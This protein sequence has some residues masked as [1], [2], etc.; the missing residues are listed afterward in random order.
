[1][2]VF[3]IVASIFSRSVALL[4]DVA[5][6][7][8]DFLSALLTLFAERLAHRPSTKLMSYGFSRGT[9]V[10]AFVNG[11]S[12]ILLSVIILGQSVVRL[13]YPEPVKPVWM[14]VAALIAFLVD[15]VIVWMLVHGVN[16]SIE[17]DVQ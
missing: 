2:L 8:T 9:V 3:E 10:A 7:G 16:S 13:I 1:M 6:V 11:F 12:L 14:I 15:G 4:S 5:H 17:I